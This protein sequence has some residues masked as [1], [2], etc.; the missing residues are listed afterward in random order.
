MEG[1]PPLSYEWQDAEGNLLGNSLNLFN[2]G[3]GNYFL[4]VTDGN[5]CTTRS[6]AFT[7]TDAG[8]IAVDTV[9]VTPAHCGQAD[10]SITVS[11]HS[12]ATGF[13][14]YSINDGNSFQD[15]NN[16]FL[17]LA[18]GDY[19]IRVADTNGCETVYNHNPVTV[20]DMP[21]PEV[22]SVTVA[23]ETN[24]DQ[25]GE[26]HI[27]ATGNG[28]LEYSVNNGTNFQNSGDFYNLSAGTY[29]CVVRDEYGCD[30]AFEVTV[31]RLS[32]SLLE[33]VAG[34][35]SSCLGNA[36]VV[37]L[38]VTGFDSVVQFRA[39]LTYDSSL[40]VC[41]GYQNTVQA[42]E[43]NLHV[44]TVNNDNRVILTWQQQN[45]VTLPPNATLTELVFNA[46]R[47]GYSA[48]D[49]AHAAGESSFVNKNG[50]TLQTVYQTGEVMIFSVPDVMLT[51]GEQVCQGGQ[52][53]LA[54]FVTGGAGVYDY[55]WTGPDDFT[56]SQNIVYLANITKE[57]AGV[58]SFTVTDTVGCTATKRVTIEVL[59]APVTALSE[60]DT[61]FL[62]PGEL[63][64]AGGN[65][66]SY[67]W[68]TG[69]TTAAILPDT[70]GFYTLITE[71]ENGCKSYDTVQ[72]LW[73]GIPFAVPNAFT[74][75]GDGL[76]DVFKVIPKYDYLKKFS[77]QI[78]NRW[79]QLIFETADYTKGWDGTYKGTP[80]E[81]GV[82][83]YRIVYE[84][85]SSRKTEGVE[86][87]V[88]VI[89]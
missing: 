53:L 75:N 84:D 35:G 57:M 66:V 18:P 67:L 28:T 50:L 17:N 7:V 81:S 27:T 58:Y 62:N 26:I 48:V 30:T 79:G 63:L 1:V 49:W 2:L 70:M 56:S 44:Q 82:Y 33:A 13:L 42:I 39:E 24:L 55:L 59:P 36:A 85:F 51:P 34:S 73:N 52:L 3:V 80:V 40:L 21:G 16:T 71:G 45:G 64:D 77:M 78:Y 54:P 12:A 74:P 43:N 76:N 22:L 47:E 68:N 37:P 32:T 14:R 6:E 5:G 11:A 23:D 9:S 60:A 41:T 25:N 65:A 31:N 15:N 29:F 8:D 46:K 83:V 61:L 88:V 69:D 38:S 86:G 4:L 19:V 72:I 87:N 89:R 20:T 10:G